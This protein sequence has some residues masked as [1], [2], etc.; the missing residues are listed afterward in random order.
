MPLIV[1]PSLLQAK[2]KVPVLSW[3]QV[4]VVD[5]P[6]GTAFSDDDMLS[7]LLGGS[8]NKYASSFRPICNVLFI[9]A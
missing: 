4:N 5:D 2:V 3:L 9:H 7:G 8:E 1:C 6:S